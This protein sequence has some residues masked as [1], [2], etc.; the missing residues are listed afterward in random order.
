MV[1]QRSREEQRDDEETRNDG[2]GG[3]ASSDQGVHALEVDVQLRSA[4]ELPGGRVGCDLE[5]D[6]EDGD[7]GD[8]DAPESDLPGLGETRLV[9]LIKVRIDEWSKI[10]LAE[11]LLGRAGETV[12]CG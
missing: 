11:M 9:E 2:I 1:V 5:T 10:G 3:D 8:G 7:E 4:H 6:E 12:E